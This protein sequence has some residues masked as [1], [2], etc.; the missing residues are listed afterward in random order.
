MIRRRRDYNITAAID[1]I[2]ARL[3]ERQAAAAAELAA[4]REEAVRL[5]TERRRARDAE[6]AEQSQ[7][8]RD[9]EGEQC[10]RKRRAT[11]IEWPKGGAV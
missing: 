1:A 11:V 8:E 10:E 9:R 3:R 5:Q 6:W 7:A 2:G 4:E